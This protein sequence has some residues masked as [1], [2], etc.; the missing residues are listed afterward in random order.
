MI[1]YGILKY[2]PVMEWRG[3][4]GCSFSMFLC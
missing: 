4:S 1:L 3:I 2:K